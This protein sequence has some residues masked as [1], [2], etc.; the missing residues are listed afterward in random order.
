MYGN[1]AENVIGFIQPD[2]AGAC[3]H[4]P[5]NKISKKKRGYEMEKLKKNPV[6]SNRKVAMLIMLRQ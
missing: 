6:M 5:A 1:P 4:V 3:G 2:A